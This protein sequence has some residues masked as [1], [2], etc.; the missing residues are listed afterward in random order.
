M[1]VLTAPLAI[2][3]VDNVIVGKMKNVRVAESYTRGRVVGLGA[4]NPS[5]VPA[6][7]FAGTLNASYYVINFNQHPFK[8]KA[9]LRKTNNVLNFINTVLLD[10]EGFTVDLLKKAADVNTFPPDGRDANGIIHATEVAFATV[11]KAFITSDG[12]DI[13]EGQIAGRDGAFEYL[14]PIVYTV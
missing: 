4:L 11:R 13:T 9:L 12:F 5:E 14:D 10:E 7:A 8:N 3:K 1:G 6:T 2:I